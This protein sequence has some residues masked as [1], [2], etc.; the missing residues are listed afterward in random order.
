MN[1]YTAEGWTDFLVASAGAAGALTG[2]V[3]LGITINVQQI[4]SYPG[5]PGRAAATLVVLM[6]ALR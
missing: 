1:I 3:F 5:L 2:L 6:N 4:I